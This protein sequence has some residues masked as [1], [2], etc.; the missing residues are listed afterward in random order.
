MN[1]QAM[2]FDV[3][4]DSCL[5]SL[6]FIVMV[7]NVSNSFPVRRTTYISSCQRNVFMRGF[8]MFFM[9]LTFRD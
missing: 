8:L 6:V 7:T 3:M 4:R 2:L 9:T 5:V 1:V